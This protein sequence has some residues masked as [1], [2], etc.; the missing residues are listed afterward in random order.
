MNEAQVVSSGKTSF[1]QDLMSATGFERQITEVSSAY[2]DEDNGNR[3][4]SRPLDLLSRLLPPI[5]DGAVQ[6][7]N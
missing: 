7:D 2:G 4:L 1:S 6:D 5:I 3:Q